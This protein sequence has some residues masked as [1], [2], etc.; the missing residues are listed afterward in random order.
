[1]QYTAKK[2]KR[3]FEFVDDSAIWESRELGADENSVRTHPAR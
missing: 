2:K 1:M 3:A